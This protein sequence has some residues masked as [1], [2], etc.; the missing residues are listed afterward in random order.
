M[1]LSPSLPQNSPRSKIV[2]LFLFL[3]LL[4]VPGFAQFGDS[5]SI[6]P[7][8]KTRLDV[9]FF[10]GFESSPWTQA[11]GL[12]WGPEPA[13]GGIL[14]S[15]PDAF[16]GHSLRV[17]YSKGTFSSGGGFQ[18][19][20]D[21]SKFPIEPQESLYF[22]YYVRFDPGFDFVKG[23]KLPGLAGG[24]GNTGGH[25]ANGTD[26]WSARVMWRSDG[27]IVQYVYHPDQVGDYGEDF[28]WNY[29]GCPRFFEPGKW[30]CLE[31]Y[32]RMNSLGKKDGIIRSWLNGEQALEV[33]NLRFRD[34]EKLKIDKMYFETFFGG[35]DPSWATPRDQFAM[36]DN[37]VIATNP[38][39]PDLDKKSRVETVP[40][41][42]LVEEKEDKGTLVFDGDQNGWKTSSWS[43]GTYDFHSA[44]Q[45]HGASGSYS[46]LVQYPDKGWGGVQFEGPASNSKAIKTLN[47]WVYP[48]GCDVEFRVRFQRN[49]DTV[50]IEQVVTGA[51]RHGW[52]VNQWN[53]VR[54]PLDDFKIP[55]SFNKIALTSNSAQEVSPFYVDDVYLK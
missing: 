4:P 52:K 10:G 43:A 23:G 31:T 2:G 51:P 45:N 19:L 6:E 41:P 22:R 3:A 9:L 50:G 30:E 17:K 13:D 35:G 24:K 21:F 38:I 12:L 5:N 55:D 15:S 27:K 49:D 53:P 28:P 20:T 7:G 48:T 25:K 26:G 29:G 11:W 33:T 44:V 34:V 18:C 54:I 14:I 32:V 1:K 39:G 42:V 16:D 37:F 8:L 40:S 46:A 47:L 36:F